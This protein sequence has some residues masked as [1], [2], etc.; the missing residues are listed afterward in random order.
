MPKGWIPGPFPYCTPIRGIIGC[1]RTHSEMELLAGAPAT[2][3]M[4]KDPFG[5]IMARPVQW[6]RDLH[7]LRDRAGGARTETWSRV[8]IEH[9]FGIGRASAESHEGHWSGPDRGG[10]T[11]TSW[12]D[13]PWP[14]ESR[15][16]FPH[17]PTLRRRQAPRR[18][19]RRPDSSR[20]S[21]TYICCAYLPHMHLRA[22]RYRSICID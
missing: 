15:W 4:L 20:R 6:A 8:D 13:G 16:G 14:L 7:L 10:R 2:P 19:D 17:C 5:R 12:S 22:T 3:G 9:L 21:K 18:P 11:L 1:G